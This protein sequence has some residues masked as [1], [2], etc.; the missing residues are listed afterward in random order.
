MLMGALQTF[1]TAVQYTKP[2][3]ISTPYRGLGAVVGILILV[4]ELGVGMVGSM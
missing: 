3:W 2:S 4:G 1:S